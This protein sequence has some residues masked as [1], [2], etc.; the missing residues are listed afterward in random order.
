LPNAP[1]AGDSGRRPGLEFYHGA[2]TGC[3]KLRT[4]GD[5]ERVWREIHRVADL[6]NVY[7]V[8]W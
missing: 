1:G 6:H 5:L 3:R 8:E 4:V 2:L 7:N